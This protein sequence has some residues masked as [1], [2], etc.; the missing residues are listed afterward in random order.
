MIS[1]SGL[2][3]FRARLDAL[4]LDMAIDHGLRA[5]ADHVAERV[6]AALST[7]PGG[8]HQQPWLRAGALRESVG[9]SADD[10]SAVVASASPVAVAQELGTGKIPPRPFLGPTAAAETDAAVRHIADAINGSVQN[11]QSIA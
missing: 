10:S 4:D 6:R 3:E 9:V 8:P 1:I 5:A 2:A 11:G 7:P